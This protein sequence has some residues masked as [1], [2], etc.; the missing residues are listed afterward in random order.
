MRQKRRTNRRFLA[1]LPT[2]YVIVNAISF[3]RRGRT[4]P[5][6]RGDI[7]TL[8]V[9]TRGTKMKTIVMTVTLSLAAVS[10]AIAG[11]PSLTCTL[12]NGAPCTA[13]H[14]KN[15]E[16]NVRRSA[17][18]SRAGLADVKRL[19]VGSNGTVTCEQTNGKPCT[20]QQVK[21]VRDLSANSDLT[22]K[23]SGN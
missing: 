5:G 20:A 15:L 11:A 17:T 14:V 2:N 12:Q 19:S 8:A 6:H 21:M 13:Q 4:T 3:D 22:V 1:T 16:A 10:G 23:V 18:G 7:R 9:E